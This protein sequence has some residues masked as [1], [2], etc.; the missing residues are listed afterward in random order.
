METNTRQ[1]NKH[2]GTNIRRM[3]EMM[4]IKQDVLASK[5][6][7]SQQKISKIEQSESIEAALLEQVAEA[8][9]VTKEAIQNFDEEKIIYNIVTN[10]SNNTSVS[11]TN[12][13]CTFNPLEKFVEAVDKIEKLYQDLLESEKEK[14]AILKEQLGKK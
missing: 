1:P 5:L 4:G 11:G 7:L 6:G 3:R 10:N 8:L 13:Y 9:G 14:V 2:I 12:Y